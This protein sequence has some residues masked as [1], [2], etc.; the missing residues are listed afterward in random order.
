MIIKRI[1][2]ILLSAIFLLNLNGCDHFNNKDKNYD[3][4]TNLIIDELNY[5]GT[6]LVTC[7]S[8]G[9]YTAVAEIIITQGIISGEITN[10]QK[11]RFKIKGTVTDGGRISFNTI[12][13]SVNT[14]ITS[15][16]S[17]D[18][19]GVIKGTYTIA[20]RKGDYFGFKF[21]KDDKFTIKYDGLY[22]IKF[23]RGGIN[24]ADSKVRINNGKFD[25]LI[26]TINDE[27]YPVSGVVSREGNLII[28]TL[29]NQKGMGIAA[30]GFITNHGQINGL[31][32][33]NTGEKGHFLGELIKY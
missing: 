16:G 1:Y 5:N 3:S 25:L 19:D 21:S 7:I 8:N 13:S 9:I 30:S 15:I 20:N 32:Y 4:K 23:I 2:L 26:K 33:F 29:F 11:M 18:A 28:K 6:Y 22:R 10:T 24:V 31:Y 27:S 17:I 12:D 14:K